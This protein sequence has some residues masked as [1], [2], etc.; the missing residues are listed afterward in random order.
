MSSRPAETGV[1]R[2]PV[3]SSMTPTGLDGVCSLSGASCVRSE[4][5]EI[6]YESRDTMYALLGDN[7]TPVSRST[8][9]GYVCLAAVTS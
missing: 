2:Q 9:G 3:I 5:L 8:A 6:A 1:N 4:E 7:H